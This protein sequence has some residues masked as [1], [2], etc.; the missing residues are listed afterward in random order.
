MQDR[1]K[2]MLGQYEVIAKIGQGGMAHVFKANHPALN[3]LVA[4][5][6]L[7]PEL[8][9]Q[10]GFAERFRREAQAVARLNH[11]NILPVYDFGVQ[12]RYS[13]IVMRYIPNSITLHSLMGEN[14]SKQKLI[15]YVAQ[16]AEALNYT[17]EQGIIHRDVK[18]A[19]ILIDDNWA[20]LSDFGLVK[21]PANAQQLTA[22]LMGMGTPAYM[23]PEHAKGQTVDHRTDI[24]ALGIVL[25][26]IL[27]GTVPHSATTPLA[28]IAKRASQ[29]VPDVREI[30]ADVSKSLGQ[31]TM[32]ALAQDPDRRY[33]S[34][35]QFAQ[36]I[37][38]ALADPNYLED[39]NP[40]A[41]IPLGVEMGAES[42]PTQL[43][44]NP[45]PFVNQGQVGLPTHPLAEPIAINSAAIQSGS[46]VTLEQLQAHVEAIKTCHEYSR[47]A[48]DEENANGVDNGRFLMEEGKLLP[49]HASPYELDA[50]PTR[51]GLLDILRTN[52]QSVVLGEAGSG[53]TTTLE[54]LMWEVA[55][56]Q[57][58]LSI[59]VMVRLLDFSGDLIAKIK[60]ELRARGKLKVNDNDVVAWLE[61]EQID[62][63][64]MFDGLNEVSGSQREV[65]LPRMISLMKSYPQH[66]YI[67]TSRVQDDQWERLRQ[68]FPDLT[69]SV[70]QPIKEEQIKTY[71]RAHLGPRRWWQVWRKMD[72]RLKGLAKRP[73]M[74]WLVKE[75]AVSE[76][77][78]LPRNRGELFDS[79]VKRALRREKEKG[80]A[81]IPDHEKRRGLTYLA[82]NMQVERNL[83]VTFEAA[84]QI[85]KRDAGMEEEQAKALLI[86]ASSNGL[87]YGDTNL[88]FMHQSLQEHFVANKLLK[89]A[90]AEMKTGPVMQ[91][92]GMLTSDQW[93]D[94]AQDDWWAEPFIHTAGLMA[95]PDWLVKKLAKKNPWLAYWCMDEGQ[96][97][98]EKTRQFVEQSSTKQLFDSDS[99]IRYRAVESLLRLNNA[100]VMNYLPDLL[101]DEDISIGKM[102]YQAFL[103]QAEVPVE[104]LL[105]L[106]KDKKAHTRRWTVELLA[107]QDNLSAIPH[108]TPLL[109]DEDESVG[110]L[111]YKTL[112]ACQ[113][114]PVKPLLALLADIDPNSSSLTGAKRRAYAW[115]IKLLTQPDKPG[116]TSQLILNLTSPNLRLRC[117]LV[118]ILAQHDDPAIVPAL[119]P[120]LQDEDEQVGQA[121]YQVLLSKQDLTKDPFLPMLTDSREIV[122]QWVAGILGKVD[123][124]TIIH[125][126]LPLLRD[127]A[128]S[129]SK[130]AYY[131]LLNYHQDIS[132]ERLLPLMRNP[133]PSVRLCALK[134][135]AK[136][137]EPDITL[138][139]HLIAL[140]QDQ[141][142]NVGGVAGQILLKY[143]ELPQE[144]FLRLLTSRRVHIR[145][146]AIQILIQTNPILKN[147]LEFVHVP[148]GL[149]LMGVDNSRNM[150]ERPQHQVYLGDFWIS[151]QPVSA[152]QYNEYIGAATS[153]ARR[154]YNL[155]H[156]VT[157]VSW[158]DAVYYCKWLSEVTGLSIGLPTEAQWEKAARGTEG[159]L[160]PWGNNWKP[161][162]C[163]T[164]EYNAHNTAPVNKFA[165]SGDSPFSCQDMIGNVWEWTS[166]E[167]R[168]YPYKATD[169]R[170]DPNMKEAGRVVRGGSFNTDAASVT[171][172]TRLW[173]YPNVSRDDLGFRVVIK[174]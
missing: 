171:C 114:A 30:E 92:I 75:A 42:A 6:V 151:R 139:P 173:H 9:S 144:P 29:P 10:P 107:Q 84:A 16:V 159:Q 108:V 35:A 27:T 133:R 109:A 161:N 39:E 83:S 45:P 124:P 85:V 33:A 149:F 48:T 55:S 164:R 23:S 86:E 145:H 142:D 166:S 13:Y 52:S 49:I 67:I 136:Q 40:Y 21:E 155:D 90:E 50:D 120:L 115:V 148:A 165:S 104:P 163:N 111:V 41:T 129:V 117:E 17:H 119:I 158:T 74:L 43:A 19:N 77:G 168:S 97:V 25:Y 70:V 5:K 126:L 59:P 26:E 135:L 2:R 32:R 66:R 36:A 57:P 174:L 160:Y 76:V 156:P 20:L 72:G 170:E 51:I 112:E 93:S 130:A 78:T 162:I 3:R 22:T 95:Q 110:Q 106:L 89:D 65:L 131:A 172:A 1:S 123:D 38:R 153:L 37:R 71:L 154:R 98:T 34:A 4:I 58:K 143:K 150:L 138:V 157:N 113:P 63:T 94:L 56:H 127:E 147:K 122:R 80:E 132:H 7:S 54:R 102:V 152:A 128:E 31:V 47:W 121:V 24:Y 137:K 12:G 81:R 88:R 8:V 101:A 60:D 146:Q 14:A 134:L 91:F 68:I 99:R 62:L 18:P 140:L 118:N 69:V 125:H 73:L 11:P 53:K 15:D 96:A 44:T 116:I 82:W 105:P 169:G 103:A 141:N 87:L 167:H 79:F 46:L 28:I 100:R 61:S 64:I